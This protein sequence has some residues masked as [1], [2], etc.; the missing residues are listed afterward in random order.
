LPQRAR[1]RLPGVPRTRRSWSCKS[2]PERPSQGHHRACVELARESEWAERGIGIGITAAPAEVLPDR[3][4]VVVLHLDPCPRTAVIAADAAKDLDL[5]RKLG[6]RQVSR[7]AGPAPYRCTNCPR[8][9][10]V[11]KLDE[12]RA[13]DDRLRALFHAASQLPLRNHE[14]NSIHG[15]DAS[16][17]GKSSVA[18]SCRSRRYRRVTCGINHRELASSERRCAIRV[19]RTSQGTECS[20]EAR[21]RFSPQWSC[22]SSA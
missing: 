14:L 11:E 17:V 20:S 21:R 18:R 1:S 13:V 12:A 15:S 19:R 4:V 5:P 3:L 22:S 9:A 6:T 16:A 10:R 8:A 7:T 2:L